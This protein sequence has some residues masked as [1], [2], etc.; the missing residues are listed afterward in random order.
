MGVKT[1]TLDRECEEEAEGASTG[2]EVRP[3][4]PDENKVLPS[5]FCS[6]QG[7]WEE[8]GIWG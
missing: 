7:C 3:E 2:A 8:S 5:R 1:V 4:L 6:L